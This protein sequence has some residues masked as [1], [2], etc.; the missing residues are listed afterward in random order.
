MGFGSKFS[1]PVE[2]NWGFRQMELLFHSSSFA[3][4][5]RWQGA[6][7][8]ILRALER[9]CKKHRDEFNPLLTGDFW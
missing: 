2:N 9:K 7:S 6:Q 4:A 5:S 8:Q 3:L 1:V